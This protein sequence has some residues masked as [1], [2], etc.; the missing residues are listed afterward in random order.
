M[1]LYKIWEFVNHM[2][3]YEANKEGFFPIELVKHYGM[4]NSAR[5]DMTVGWM[6][7][8][9]LTEKADMIASILI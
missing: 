7:G 4:S 2:R 3:Y 8:F 5:N 1:K 6:N 9:A